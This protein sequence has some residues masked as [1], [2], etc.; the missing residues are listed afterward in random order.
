MQQLLVKLTFCL[1]PGADDMQEDERQLWTEQILQWMCS[2]DSTTEIRFAC[3]QALTGAF[4]WS[5]WILLIGLMC[6]AHTEHALPN[7]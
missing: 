3:G 4:K 2:P 5:C 7:L 6:M 1:L